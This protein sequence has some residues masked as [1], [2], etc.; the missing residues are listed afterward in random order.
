MGLA[1]L[2]RDLRYSV[3]SLARSPGFCAVAVL[4]LA[5]GIGANTA[6]FSVVNGMLLQ[7]LPYPNADRIVHL[8]ATY[9]VRGFRGVPVAPLDFLDWREQNETF[10]RLTAG[11][12]W[13]Y[14]LSGD[15]NPE[16]LHGMRVSPGFFQTLGVQTMLGRTFRPE[17]D[18]PGRDRVVILTHGLWE[19]RFS[20]DPG[21]I[22][23]TISIEAEPFTVIG[24]LPP[25]F[26]FYPILGKNVEIWMPMSFNP[27][28]LSRDARSIMVHGLLKPG[29]S[30][31]Q[32]R[33]EMDSITAN[34]AQQYPESN[35]GWG[36]EVIPGLLSKERIQPRILLLFAAVGF[37]LLIACANVANLTL[38]RAF[39]RRHE[40]ALR[41]AL[42]AGRGTLIRQLLVESSVI[43]GLGCVAGLAA[44]AVCL[45][46]VKT[47]L[48][49]RLEAFFYGG[50]E[51]LRLDGTVLAFTIAATLLS[52]LLL[53]L[54]PAIQASRANL[55]DALKASERGSAG[56]VKGQR[57]RNVLMAAQV[58]LAITLSVGAG[59][60][61]RSLGELQQVD[62]GLNTSHVLTAQIWPPENK[63]IEPRDI[64]Q[65]QQRVLERLESLPGASSSSAISFLPLSEAGVGWNF[66]IEGRPKPVPEERPSAMYSVVAP[67][68]FETMQIPLVRGRRLT[69]ADGATAPPVAV[70]DE[71][72]AKRYWPGEDPVGK[73]FRFDPTDGE[74]PWQA[75]LNPEWITV[76]G[77]AQTVSG[78][79]LW[80]DGAPLIYLPYQQNPSR[81]MHL[82]VRTEQDPLS[83]ANAVR[84]RVWEVD[85]DQPVSFVRSME[86]VPAWALA[87]R[88]LT[89]QLLAVFAALAAV[90]AAAGIYGVVSYAVSQRVQEVGI[91]MALGA[92]GRQVAA[93]VVSQGLKPV[94]AGVIAGAAGAFALT[95]FLSSQL[96]G[97]SPTDPRT[98]AVA[99][100]SLIL[101]ALLACYIPARRASK[102]DPM[103]ALRHE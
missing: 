36:A 85:P 100:L 62:R 95:R 73:R 49:S 68:Y 4:T 12:F 10:E 92:Q 29:V 56:G 28:E 7:P 88:R 19:R 30:I 50:L 43:A 90:L 41:A 37:V 16:Q 80:E 102:V 47:L 87:E 26:W 13:F 11:R 53:G 31:E 91:R 64:A 20:S 22:G 82:V 54:L 17:E 33:A 89:M 71:K 84:S 83:M 55:G 23:K 34:I 60:M 1:S 69:A 59:L 32:A 79:G 76:V 46:L 52:A 98:L 75:S 6:M 63:Y 40:I 18:Q 99:C 9:E 74:S 8:W 67:G 15:G 39:R 81:M 58:A 48:S 66:T 57:V 94:L 86:E 96:Y 35:K 70:I 65:F 21:L 14:T 27:A 78:D 45:R 25:D 77:I 101:V 24:V 93:M 103:T 38:A 3:R 61:I 72:L 2:L 44:G 97:V 5:V 51:T 42:G